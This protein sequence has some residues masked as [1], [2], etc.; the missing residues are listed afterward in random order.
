MLRR[1]SLLSAFNTVVNASVMETREGKTRATLDD[2]TVAPRRGLYSKP[3]H[4]TR[5]RV[6]GITEWDLHFSFHWDYYR[7]FSKSLLLF[8]VSLSQLH[9]N[10]WF[11]FFFA[12][13][14]ST[15]LT[16]LRKMKRHV[17]Y[18]RYFMYGFVFYFYNTA[19]LTHL[20][21]IFVL[22]FKI[23]RILRTALM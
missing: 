17:L 12:F 4:S 14:E 1:R 21:L 20:S 16:C 7:L 22:E 3:T 23:F 2:C 18:L 11:V 15:L 5:L 8:F 9:I 6:P 10:I 19:K 13:A